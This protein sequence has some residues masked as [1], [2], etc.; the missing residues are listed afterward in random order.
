MICNNL[1]NILIR[2]NHVCV[3]HAKINNNKPIYIDVNIKNSYEANKEI[4]KMI[5]YLHFP[6]YNYLIK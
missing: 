6:Q 5:N 4:N 1:K 2:L 3:K